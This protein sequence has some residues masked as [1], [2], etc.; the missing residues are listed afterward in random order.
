MMP[1]LHQSMYNFAQEGLN[2]WKLVS[3]FKEIRSEK[4]NDNSPYIF[5][6]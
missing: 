3:K 5:F 1:H 2:G 6:P 4:M